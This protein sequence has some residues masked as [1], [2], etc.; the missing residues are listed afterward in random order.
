MEFR[1]CDK[2][3]V[4][5]VTIAPIPSRLDF[6]A[7]ARSA[8]DFVTEP[9]YFMQ[10]FEQDEFRI[11]YEGDDLIL[12]LLHDPLS[13]ELDVA[14]WRPSAD[15]EVKHPFALADIIRI[16][17][18]AKARTY[19]RFSATS[20]TAVRRGI[21]ELVSDLRTY[22][23][24]ALRGEEGFYRKMSAARS[25]AARQFGLELTDKAARANAEQSWHERDF[26]RV[27]KAYRSL[28]DRLSKVE[29]ERLN[30][31]IRQV[32]D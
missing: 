13:Y 20:K 31:A 12:V 8:L 3:L 30:Y 28:E 16:A 32:N 1:S 21:G 4:F 15:D 7:T 24:V 5:A 6:V 11:G 18:P 29:R 2:S 10:I 17:D 9:P 26:R 22:G 19:R 27:I 25:E 14:L 23:V